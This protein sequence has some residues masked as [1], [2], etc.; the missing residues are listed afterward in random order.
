MHLCLSAA[1]KAKGLEFDLVILVD[2]LG[3]SN[4]QQAIGELADENSEGSHLA[5]FAATADPGDVVLQHSDTFY[6]M[7]PAIHELKIL[8]TAITRSRFGCAILEADAATA[9]WGRLLC[10]WLQQGAVEYLSDVSG[11]AD[12]AEKGPQNPTSEDL[13]INTGAV[14]ETSESESETGVALPAMVAWLEAEL[15]QRSGRLHRQAR[16][17]LREELDRLE[18]SEERVDPSFCQDFFALH[19]MLI[20]PDFERQTQRKLP[21]ATTASLLARSQAGLSGLQPL[22]FSLRICLQRKQ[23]LSVPWPLGNWC[24][25]LLSIQAISN[26]PVRQ[27]RLRALRKL[28]PPAHG[29]WLMC[30]PWLFSCDAWQRNVGQNLGCILPRNNCGS[31]VVVVVV[32]VVVVK[33][34]D[35]S[36]P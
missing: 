32:V 22:G 5:M 18:S 8:Y 15:E 31:H 24:G 11:Y 27:P 29:I 34:T 12:R 10:H 23:C 35:P 3:K 20:E 25:F 17:S 7:V 30:P 4:Y 1:G 13:P 26:N 2:L 16:R 14:E 33:N 28:C 36:A 21:Q 19:G 6:K 9:P